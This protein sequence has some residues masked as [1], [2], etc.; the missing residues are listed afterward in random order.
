MPRRTLLALVALVLLVPSTIAVAQEASPIASPAAGVTV[1]TLAAVALPA[2]AIPAGAASVGW[3]HSTFAPGGSASQP[4]LAP[5][6]V[7]SVNA[8]L[9]GRAGVTSAGTLRVVRA[10]GTSE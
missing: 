8:V 5:Q 9:A 1:E 7:V 2:A 10:D 6:R 4:D 3:I